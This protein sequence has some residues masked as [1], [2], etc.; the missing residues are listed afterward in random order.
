MK[1]ENKAVPLLNYIGRD[2]HHVLKNLCLSALPTNNSYEVLKQKLL[3]HYSPT[4]LLIAER[5]RFHERCQKEGEFLTDFVVA[6]KD[7]AR[8][9][10]FGAFVDQALRDRLVTG[11]RDPEIKSALLELDDEGFD[12][13]FKVATAKEL[14]MAKSEELRLDVSP[15]SFVKGG[16]PCD[17][18]ASGPPPT[19]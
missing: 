5:A 8:T 19:T 3:E 6:I 12:S 14:A 15:K 18:S 9:C 11:C 2:G 13:C 1:T 4:R 16:A 7:L 10:K 17:G